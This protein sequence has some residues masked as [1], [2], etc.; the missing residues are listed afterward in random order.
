MWQQRDRERIV[1]NGS[2]ITC[3]ENQLSMVDNHIITTYSETYVYT[4]DLGLG[5]DRNIIVIGP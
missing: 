4:G 5:I 2:V 1:G 3:N